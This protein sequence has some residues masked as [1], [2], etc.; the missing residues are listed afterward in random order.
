MPFKHKQIHLHEKKK[1]N[2][3]LQTKAK[4]NNFLFFFNLK[5]AY[6]N[7]VKNKL[8]KFITNTTNKNRKKG[9]TQT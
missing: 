7:F 4:T 8:W 3:V 2:N 1:K 5:K 6:L 9:F